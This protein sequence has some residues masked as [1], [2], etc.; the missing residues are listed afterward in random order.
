MEPDRLQRGRSMSASSYP[1][2]AQP[3][4]RERENEVRLLFVEHSPDYAALVRETLER[5][6]RGRFEVCHANRLE[7]AVDDLAAGG[8]DALLLD[9]TGDHGGDDDGSTTIDAATQIA[10]RL[11]VIVLTGSE[12]DPRIAPAPDPASAIHDGI[13]H[14]R[15]PDAILGAVRRHRRL[16]Q[17]GAAEPIV[18]R[19]PLRCFARVFAKLRR[20]LQR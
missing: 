17:Q 8:Y 3:G 5:A 16:G 19:D 15:L 7:A 12:D 13:A 9:W 2:I 10:S 14:S 20:S 6:P 11:P 18:L 4:A 1:E